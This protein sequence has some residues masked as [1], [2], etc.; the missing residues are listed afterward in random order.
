MH[1]KL[2]KY[3]VDRQ[4]FESILCGL[5]ILIWFD[6]SWP[7]SK[8]IERTKNISFVS[9]L[10]ET[11]NYR[12]YSLKLSRATQAQQNHLEFDKYKANWL[13]AG[14][15]N[16]MR[17][18]H[19]KQKCRKFGEFFDFVNNSKQT[20][21]RNSSFFPVTLARYSICLLKWFKIIQ[22]GKYI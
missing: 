22:H 18:A 11:A 9:S 16:S 1:L 4:P 5:L 17:L 20:T 7:C 10:V 8:T 21:N 12:I 13:N 2:W 6:L 19:S 14:Q 15:V 3:K